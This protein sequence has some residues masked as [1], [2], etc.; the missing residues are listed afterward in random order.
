MLFCVATSK[1]QCLVFHSG[2]VTPNSTCDT[3]SK[4][5]HTHTETD[6]PGKEETIVVSSA[7]SMMG[8][9]HGIVTVI[10]QRWRCVLL[11]CDDKSPYH[12][13]LITL[14]GMVDTHDSRHIT[15]L[16]FKLD[17]CGMTSCKIFFFIKKMDNRL[18]TKQLIVLT[19]AGW[20]WQIGLLPGQSGPSD[21]WRH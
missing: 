6:I 2:R 15:Q 16:S 8:A 10:P 3:P 19:G 1:P 7:L 4:H 18:Q 13:R 14:I 12:V 5:T 20:V 21:C 11:P 9:F 17:S